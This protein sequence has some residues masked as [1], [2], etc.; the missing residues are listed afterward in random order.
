MSLNRPIAACLVA[1]ATV[2]SLAANAQVY[3]IVG[4][5]GRVTFSDK[6]PPPDV[7]ASA[8]PVVPMA[9]GGAAS[10]TLPFELR[11]TVNR[12]PVVLY[13]G[14]N[15]APCDIARNFLTSRGVPFT[16]KTVSS[17]DDVQALQRLSGAQSLPFA[18]IG[19]QQLKGFSE[20]EWDQFLDAAGYPKT[21]QLPSGYRN[22]PA[23]PLV[24]STQAP[25]QAATR[26]GAGQRP[27]Q[28]PQPAAPGQ[29]PDNPAGI[30]F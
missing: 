17:A 26:P 4:P 23:T 25:P 30:Q 6:P 16:E 29:N 27:A 9:G 13:S 21:S 7:K 12:Y 14:A 8:A 15:C 3:R 28:Q 10:S 11:T 20:Q 18:T 19:G 24:A 22:P 2:W 5:D 1:L